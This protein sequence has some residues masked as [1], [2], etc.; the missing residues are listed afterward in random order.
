MNVAGLILIPLVAGYAFSTTWAASRYHVKRDEGYGLYFKVALYSIAL[1]VAGFLS[2]LLV[3]SKHPVIHTWI[4]STLND[5]APTFHPTP[6]DETA[7]GSMAMTLAIGL[8]AGH[9]MNF[10]PGHNRFFLKR[11]IKNDDFERLVIR[12]IEKSMPMMVTLSNN[13]VY[14]GWVI[15]ALDPGNE[16]KE[17]RI[18]PLFSG[19]RSPTSGEVDFTTRYESIYLEIIRS[20]K[21]TGK[22][23]APVV[24]S[25]DHLEAGDFEIIIPMSQVITSSLFDRHAYAFFHKLPK[26]SENKPKQKLE[27]KKPR[28]NPRYGKGKGR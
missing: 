7:F 18:L 9:L 3:L 10:I 5:L 26:K 23:D 17:V 24:P 11:A 2:Y 25:L 12:A 27:P 6:F 4:A 22:P 20:Q 16:R 21:V 14:V 15:R 13:K 19:F 1:T 28:Q 8:L